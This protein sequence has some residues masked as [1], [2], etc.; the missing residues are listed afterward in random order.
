MARQ[1]RVNLLYQIMKRKLI[2]LAPL[3]TATILFASAIIPYDNATPPRLSLPD[4]Y[5]NAMATLGPLTN[6]FH[7]LSAKVTTDF[8]PK[9]EWQFTFYST[10]AKPKWITVEFNGKI[11]VENMMIR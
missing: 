11:H 3:A 7:C 6:E 1:I 8:S 4:A 10:N 2:L 9:G 5:S